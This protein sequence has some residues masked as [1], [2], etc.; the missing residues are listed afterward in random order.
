MTPA[1]RFTSYVTAAQQNA[2][3]ALV[4]FNSAQ[5]SVIGGIVRSIEKFGPPEIVHEGDRLRVRVGG[6][7]DAQSLFAVDGDT[8]RPLGMAIYVR[9]DVESI[10]VLHLGIAEEFTS[11]GVHAQ[12]HLLMRLV[13][14]V[15]RCIRRLKGVRR[16]EFAYLSGRN[17]ARRRVSV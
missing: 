1:I 14:E 13:W 3:E 7:T 8:G 4:F 10:V 17:G 2:L 11:A 5:Q 15:R 12:Q 6:E 9:R 16:M